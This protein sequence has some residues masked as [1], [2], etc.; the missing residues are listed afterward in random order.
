MEN[1]IAT[2]EGVRRKCGASQKKNVLGCQIAEKTV[3]LSKEGWPTLEVENL[4]ADALKAMKKRR[5]PTID[6]IFVTTSASQ[7]NVDNVD[8]NQNT[9]KPQ[10]QRKS[11]LKRKRGPENASGLAES[12]G[13]EDV[14]HIEEGFKA[15]SREDL[16]LS[17]LAKQVREIRELEGRVMAA[18]SG[19]GWRNSSFKTSRVTSKRL[20]DEVKSKL[21]EIGDV[22]E[23]MKPKPD[24]D[25]FEECARLGPLVA[26]AED[27]K[28]ELL[29]LVPKFRE[30]AKKWKNNLNKRCSVLW[31]DV[32]NVWDKMEVT[33][34]SQQWWQAMSSLDRMF[35]ES[36][37]KAVTSRMYNELTVAGFPKEVFMRTKAYFSWLRS[38]GSEFAQVGELM[39]VVGVPP[40]NTKSFLR[41]LKSHLPVA[42]LRISGRTILVDCELLRWCP[43]LIIRLTLVLQ[44]KSKS[45]QDKKRKVQ[46]RPMKRKR[47]RVSF[48]TKHP[49]S[50]D[51][52]R[53]LVMT[54]VSGDEEATA[55]D[56][57][58]R[59]ELGMSNVDLHRVLGAMRTILPAGEVPSHH[60]LR[61]WMYP[62]SKNRRSAKKYFGLI[63]AKVPMKVSLF[64]LF[65]DRNS[66]IV[67]LDE[68][69]TGGG[70]RARRCEGLQGYGATDWRVCKVR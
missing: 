2:A 12:L 11:T 35:K 21:V 50:V 46:T 10:D 31:K 61:H 27:L 26:K 4:V 63:P 7:A 30:A 51:V 64:K 14:S 56:P 6:S 42:V 55:A 41:A 13:I 3:A 29:D 16:A 52:A 45:I 25:R 65:H 49:K 66:E 48:H 36:E 58:R 38:S 8:F 44:T 34:F 1:V 18:A 39:G 5:Q 69:Q 60:V 28:V 19:S 62:P 23:Q 9:E 37:E 59:D 54:G 68:H 53:S 57:R 40:K 47:D 17:G 70:V 32:D 67:L 22:V 20:Q 24:E 33:N 15:G 43:E